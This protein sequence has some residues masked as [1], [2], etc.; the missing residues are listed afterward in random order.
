[1][2]TFPCVTVDEQRVP[3]V[4]ENQVGGVALDPVAGADL[5]RLLRSVVPMTAKMKEQDAIFVSLRV[6]LKADVAEPLG[7][8]IGRAVGGIQRKLGRSFGTTL[9]QSG[10]SFLQAFGK[11]GERRV[12]TARDAEVQG[13]KAEPPGR[14]LR[15]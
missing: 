10:D 9:R 3:A 4:V 7:P 13:C 12:F 5:E 8:R 6:R 14:D 11:G 1:M 15:E 2:R